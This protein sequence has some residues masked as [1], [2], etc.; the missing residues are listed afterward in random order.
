MNILRLFSI[1]ALIAFMPLDAFSQEEEPDGDL[2][3]TAAQATVE[4]GANLSDDQVC[5][6]YLSEKGWVQGENRKSDGT[7]FYIATGSDLVFAPMSSDDFGTSMM[8]GIISSSVKAKAKLAESMGRD[9]SSQ[10]VVEIKQD[11]Q[12]GKKPEFLNQPEISQK[13]YEDM[14]AVDKMRLL[15]NQQ[16]D[17]LIDPETK[18]A[19][20]SDAAS[21]RQLERALDDVLNQREFT[22]TITANANATIRG[23]KN[24][25]TGFKAN[26]KNQQVGA[27]VVS[28]WSEKLLKQADA[29]TTGNFDLLR[30]EKPGKPV[31]R[32]LPNDKTEAGIKELLGKFGVFTTR[33]EKGN[34]FVY[35]YAQESVIG[36]DGD[37]IARRNAQLRA[38]RAIIQFREETIETGS[39]SKNQQGRVEYNDGMREYYS[40]R[41]SSDRF[42]ATAGGTL[43]GAAVAKSWRAL[44]INKKPVQ[45]VIVRWSPSQAEFFEQASEANTSSVDYG[46]SSDDDSTDY[47]GPTDDWSSTEGMGD[48]EDDF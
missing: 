42:K 32:H 9:I 22:D 41:N 6:D 25:R 12:S 34:V 48:D 29:V 36:R 37:D 4:T 30:G 31:S 21:A 13:S 16:L 14:G 3:S 43:K 23:M 38:E 26:T 24:I 17:K 15:V 18:A 8:D 2:F 45:G 5:L 44:Q 46:S 35:S 40:D 1:M 19:V 28:I 47:E 10:I 39:F 11:F 27:C 33:D 7:P 20:N